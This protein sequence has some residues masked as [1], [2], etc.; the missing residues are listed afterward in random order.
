MIFVSLYRHWPFTRATP[1]S[2][3]RSI[4]ASGFPVGASAFVPAKTRPARKTNVPHTKSAVKRKRRNDASI[5]AKR[6]SRLNSAAHVRTNALL[7]DIG[8]IGCWRGGSKNHRA[9]TRWS[10]RS[11]LVRAPLI[12]VFVTAFFF[13]DAEEVNGQLETPISSR[14]NVPAPAKAALLTRSAAIMKR[15]N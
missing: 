15:N 6:C 10:A 2:L 13:T 11:D 5:A 1:A 7:I 14:N 12:A 3:A 8:F 4:D 9:V